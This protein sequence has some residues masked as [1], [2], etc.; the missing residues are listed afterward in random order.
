VWED[1]AP[2]APGALAGLMGGKARHARAQ[3]A[4][5][6][7]FEQAIAEHG[8]GEPRPRRRCR[9]PFRHITKQKA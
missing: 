1:F 5:Q 9:G 4:A 3:E 6:A 7:A 2:P 8:V